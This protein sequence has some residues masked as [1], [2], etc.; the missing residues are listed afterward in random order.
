MKGSSA[1]NRVPHTLCVVSSPAL[2][3]RLKRS[4][5]ATGSTIEFCDS[6]DKADKR[7]YPPSLLFLDK[8]SR[9][10]A[11]LPHLMQVMDKHGKVVIIGESIADNDFVQLMRQ[12]P[13]DNVIDTSDPDESE[14]VATS[15]KLLTGDIFGLDKYLSW[16]TETRTGQVH[17]YEEKRTALEQVTEF[18]SEIGARRKI[19]SR[20]EN[21]T[22]EL[23]MNAIYNAPAAA[24]AGQ[25]GQDNLEFEV[26]PNQAPDPNSKPATITYACDGRYFGVSV[27]DYY[28]ELRKKGILD[29]LLRA[30]ESGGR[31]RAGGSGA[32]LGIF[33]VLASASRYVANIQ[34]GVKTEVICLFDMR[35][36]GREPHTCAGSLHIFTVDGTKPG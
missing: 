34:Q 4:L 26:G 11:E 24:K 20:I 9:Q 28:G 15:A 32:G 3:R 25:A 29:N 21:V 31:P 22:D 16:G 13:F 10:D 35:Q 23:L 5:H 12:Q 27:V 17:S 18:A 1:A 30:R 19:L 6:I 7:E 33:F 2:R 8:E 14:I 36:T